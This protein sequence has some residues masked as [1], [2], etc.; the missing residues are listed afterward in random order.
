MMKDTIPKLIRDQ[1]PDAKVEVHDVTGSNNHFS[2][3]VVSDSFTG[4][5][6]IKQHQTVMNI[7]K[8]ALKEKIHAVQIKTLTFEKYRNDSVKN[9]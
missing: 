8:D 2:L 6:L 1:I 7:L 3:L 5:P 9:Y 4:M